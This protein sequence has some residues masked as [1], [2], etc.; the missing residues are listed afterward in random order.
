MPTELRQSLDR[1]SGKWAVTTGE[2]DTGRFAGLFDT[3]DEALY[4]VFQV[5]GLEK[6]DSSFRRLIR[7]VKWVCG[8]G[9]YTSGDLQYWIEEV[10]EDS[11]YDELC[12]AEKSFDD[13]AELLRANKLD[14]RPE[15]KGKVAGVRKEP[16]SSMKAA[17]LKK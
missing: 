10:P 15:P 16:K 3:E 17:P 7:D 4:F 9:Y 5:C 6:L 13:F 11:Y 14:E 12:S 2:N 1:N 8:Y